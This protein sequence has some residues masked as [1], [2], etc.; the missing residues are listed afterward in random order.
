MA[1]NFCHAKQWFC[2]ATIDICR[3]TKVICRKICRI[4]LGRLLL[5]RRLS[6]ERIFSFIGLSE[7]VQYL[8]TCNVAKY[9]TFAPHW[10]IWQYFSHTIIKVILFCSFYAERYCTTNWWP[11]PA[12][13][14]C[15]L[16][17]LY[18]TH[19]HTSPIWLGII[20]INTYRL[21]AENKI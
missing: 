9:C 3:A 20:P 1:K 14:D 17:T 10:F 15:P 7:I 11:L 2:H 19:I 16:H 8:S 12:S 6:S 18:T 21:A 4:I 5:R 13:L